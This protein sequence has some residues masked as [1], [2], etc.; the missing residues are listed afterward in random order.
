MNP[1]F[2]GTFN[3][4]GWFNKGTIDATAATADAALGVAE[5][6][7]QSVKDLTSVVYYYVSPGISSLD[8]MFSLLADDDDADIDIYTGNL[9]KDPSH[10]P[11]E[12][13]LLQRLATLDVIAGQ[14]QGVIATDLF[15]DTINV[16]VDAT[17]NGM[18]TRIPGANHAASLHWDLKGANIIV[19]QGY[20]TVD[21]DTKIWLKGYA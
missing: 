9:A 15:A 16:S 18:G 5:R 19:F 2:Q 10:E 4:F 3:K 21:S 14:Q 20:G 7:F 13:C 8:V 11:D 12:D 17:L 6:T 1:K